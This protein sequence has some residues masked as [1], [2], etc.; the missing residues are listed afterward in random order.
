M[1]RVVLDTNIVVSALMSDE[2][3][4][5]RILDLAVNRLLGHADAQPLFSHPTQ[6]G[7]GCSEQQDED[8]RRRG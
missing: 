7:P 6:E 8:D 5:A 1:T 2:G 3:P 4:P